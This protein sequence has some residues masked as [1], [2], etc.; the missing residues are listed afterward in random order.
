MAI[1]YSLFGSRVNGDSVTQNESRIT[2]HERERAAFTLIELLVV[3]AIIAILAA[4][5]LPALNNARAQARSA[6]CLNNVRQIVTALHLYADD[7]HGNL[8][9]IYLARGG[10]WIHWTQGILP[11]LGRKEG[12][13]LATQPWLGWNYLRCPA[14]SITDPYKYWSTYGIQAF[15]YGVNYTGVVT[16]PIMTYSPEQPG[17][18]G[19]PASGRLANLAPGTMLLAD[20]AIQPNIYTPQTG[21][22]PLNNAPDNDSNSIILGTGGPRYNCAAFDRHPS[23]RINAAYADG[24]ARA[25]TLADWKA[26]KDHVWGY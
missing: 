4:L 22:W 14:D 21:G 9:D 6:S 8:L 25:L 16:P 2:N 18:A 11:Y 12:T 13:G 7:N 26:N 3:I 19:W 23:Q 1:R 15:T 10:S 24:S 17:F 5:L 20:S